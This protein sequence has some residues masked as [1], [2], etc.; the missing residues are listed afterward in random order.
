MRSRDF[1]RIIL[2]LLSHALTG[3]V[4]LFARI[5]SHV[6]PGAG[7]IFLAHCGVRCPDL[8]KVL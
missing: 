5:R 6:L 8:A 1:L 7:D 4:F 3:V 2:Q